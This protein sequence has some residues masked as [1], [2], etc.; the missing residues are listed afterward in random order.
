LRAIVGEHAL[1]LLLE[2]AGVFQASGDRAVEKFLVGN[3]APQKK[4]QTRSQLEV[5]QRIDSTWPHVSW[6]GFEPEQKI[7]SDEDPFDSRL[8]ARLETSLAAAGFVEL[9]E[10]LDVLV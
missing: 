2:D 4:R 7:W 10:R 5:A 9:D 6:I 3:T 1:H 8:N